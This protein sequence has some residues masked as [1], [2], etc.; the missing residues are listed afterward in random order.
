MGSNPTW[1]TQLRNVDC[2]LR[3]GRSGKR[4]IGA[5]IR[6]QLRP[7]GAVWSARHPVTVE[8]VGSNPI[9]DAFDF[10]LQKADFRFGTVRKPAKR[11][12]SNLRDRLGVRFPPVLLETKRPMRRLGIG[13]PNCL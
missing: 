3:I 6:N 4:V 2:G 11:R 8:A 5:S 7:R 1:A 9:G 10:R 12:S 13:E